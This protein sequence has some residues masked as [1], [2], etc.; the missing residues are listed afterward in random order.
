MIDLAAKMADHFGTAGT[1]YP[2]MPWPDYGPY[3]NDYDHL[4]RVAEWSITGER[5]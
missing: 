1:A 3:F 4:E 5:E 2:A